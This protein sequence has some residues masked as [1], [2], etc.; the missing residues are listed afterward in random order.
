L[1]WAST[2]IDNQ[3]RSDVHDDDEDVDDDDDDG[4]DGAVDDKDS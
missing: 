3:I 2:H 4:D 1:G